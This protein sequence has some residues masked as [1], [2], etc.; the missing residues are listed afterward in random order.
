MLMK[1]EQIFKKVVLVIKKSFRQNKSKRQSIILLS[2]TRQQVYGSLRN[3]KEDNMR[4]KN[5]QRA[6]KK[7]LNLST[8]SVKSKKVYNRKRIKRECLE[9]QK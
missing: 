9:G 1:S 6:F 7:E 4:D 8:R 3:M 2:K 5:I